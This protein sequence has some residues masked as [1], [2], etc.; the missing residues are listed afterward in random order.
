MGIQ[1]GTNTSEMNVVVVI[2]QAPGVF[3]IHAI[4]HRDV[5]ELVWECPVGFAKNGGVDEDQLNVVGLAQGHDA[6]E[7][8]IV[9]SAEN[10]LLGFA[11][12]VFDGA[13]VGF[14]K[15]A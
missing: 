3:P 6:L 2:F 7:V 13:M 10:G 11:L 9:L 8:S 5:V 14:Y 15:S 1:L 4:K 12:D